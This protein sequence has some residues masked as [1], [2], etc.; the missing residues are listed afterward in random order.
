MQRYAVGFDA[1]VGHRSGVREHFACDFAFDGEPAALG[2]EYG[3]DALAFHI[4]DP[5]VGLIPEDE[6]AERLRGFRVAWYSALLHRD[7]SLTAAT[8]VFQ[9]EHLERA[10]LAVLADEALHRGSDLRSARGTIDSDVHLRLIDAVDALFST[11]DT[12]G[13]PERGL[14]E[15]K[16]LAQEPSIVDA[17]DRAGSGLHGP[18]DASARGWAAERFAST[19]AAAISDAVQAL[20]PEF[21]IESECV[22]DVLES[23][24]SWRV[25]WLIESSPGGGGLVETVQRR[26]AE[27]PRQFIALLDRATRRTD[28]E[29]VDDALVEV[30]RELRNTDSSL[31]RRIASYRAA[32]S[33][34]ERVT[35]LRAIRRQLEELDIPSTHPVVAAL[36]A[37]V[38]RHGS[39]ER[40]D[41]A[42]AALSEC[43]RETETRLGIELDP[44]VFAYTQR[45]YGNYDAL[46]GQRVGVNIERQRIGAFASVLWARGWRARAEGLRAYSPFAEFAPTDR[47]T[48]E[49]FRSTAA[50]GI[51]ATQ[52]GW[53]EALDDHIRRYGIAVLT[54]TTGQAI[55]RALRELTVEPTDT[56][57]LLLHPIVM[58]IDKVAG[59][60]RATVLLNDGIAS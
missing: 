15:L 7:A 16:A 47:L 27:R 12:F 3:A 54:A 6:E 58:G 9:R 51:D 33:N 50:P 52:P 8:S 10:Y 53:R 48:L 41:E 40:T 13:G 46:V 37:R 39:N 35:E 55:A 22:I 59:Q 5:G 25:I 24:D 29:V 17:L 32:D 2:F 21:D 26:I 42:L 38:I 56:G 4:E 30:L 34:G 19:L 43:W 60:I 1:D 49:R 11:S 36:A 57:S 18:I 31:G 20:C 44:S 45:T 23:E 14:D 28:F